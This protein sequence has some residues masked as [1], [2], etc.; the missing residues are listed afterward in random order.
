MSFALTVLFSSTELVLFISCLWCV[1]GVKE[2]DQVL[3]ILLTTHM[4][5][6]GFLGFFLDNTIPGKLKLK[7]AVESNY[8]AV[9]YIYKL[10]HLFFYLCFI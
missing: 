1:S 2:V 7:V 5:V 3:H 10:F 8:V 4:F 6:G 9:S